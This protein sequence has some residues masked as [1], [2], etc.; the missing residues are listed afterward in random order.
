MF[1]P[2]TLNFYFQKYFFFNTNQVKDVEFSP[3]KDIQCSL[4]NIKNMSLKNSF[5][6]DNSDLKNWQYPS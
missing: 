5:F 4:S 6:N 1:D 3:R 2:F